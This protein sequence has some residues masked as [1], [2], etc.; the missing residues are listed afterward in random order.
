MGASCVKTTLVLHGDIERELRDSAHLSLESAGVL[1]ARQVSTPE[2]MRLL[3]RRMC[4]VDPSAYTAQTSNHMSIRPEGYIGA[5]ALAEA[6]TAVPIWFH[7]HPSGTSGPVPSRWD[8]QVDKDIADLFR[9]RSGSDHYGTLIFSPHGDEY[10][11]TGDIQPADEAPKPI[12]RIWVVG[13][14]WRLV[15]SQHSQPIPLDAIFDRNVRAFG[16]AIQILLGDL[17]VVITGAGGTG[18]AVAEQLVRLGV[19][20]L[21]LVD[22]DTLSA[23]NVTRVYGSTPADIGRLKV[24][25]LRDHLL[26]IAPDLKCR[27]LDEMGTLRHVAQAMTGADVLF[28]CTDDNAGRLTLSRLS[29]YFLLPIIDVGVLLSSDHDGMLHGIDG[30]I[31]TLSPGSACLACRNRIDMGRAAAELRTPQERKRLED[32]GYAPVLGQIEPAVVAFTTAVAAAAV[33]EL[34]DRL[35]GYGPP[36]HPTETLLRLHE[37]EISTNRASPRYGHYCHS[38]SGKWGAGDEE[39]FLGQLWPAP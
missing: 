30:R 5:L 28:G 35:I 24:E 37:R 34:L 1:L 38:A 25:V 4:W 8:R 20:N 2:G 18:S 10:I 11:F 33:N 15:Q 7:T 31:T 13:D 3:A 32:E 29:T 36:D 14:R 6:D 22:A 16:S 19:R 21:T 12:D 9:L 17:K 23:S 39:P 27:T 26:R